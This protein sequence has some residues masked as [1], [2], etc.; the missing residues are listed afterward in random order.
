MKIVYEHPM[1][2]I[3]SNKVLSITCYVAPPAEHIFGS[4]VVCLNYI[5]N[6]WDFFIEIWLDLIVRY[7]RVSI[8]I[9]DIFIILRD[10]RK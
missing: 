5:E 8:N 9:I 4:R 7:K 3:S 6:I 10:N 2:V 1:L